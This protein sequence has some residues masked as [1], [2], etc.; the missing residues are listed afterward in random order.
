MINT[1]QMILDF[2]K[3]N[4]ITT[5]VIFLFL[6]HWAVAHAK[7]ENNSIFTLIAV[8][9]SEVW[10]LMPGVKRGQSVLDCGDTK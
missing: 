1:D 6:K 5:S 2:I 7:V 8:T 9:L 4:G 10:G 3:D